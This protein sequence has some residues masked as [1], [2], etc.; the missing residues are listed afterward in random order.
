[1][2]GLEKGMVEDFESCEGFGWSKSEGLRSEEA[3]TDTEF[4]WKTWKWSF[5]M[6]LQACLIK[7]FI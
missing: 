3:D 1:M 6:I 5:L 7:T 4:P 2:A